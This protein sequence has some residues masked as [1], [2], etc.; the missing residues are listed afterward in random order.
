[1]TTINEHI[2][3]VESELSTL[4]YGSG[5]NV[6]NIWFGDI[7]KADVQV[8]AINFMLAR[9]TRPEDL[10]VIQTSSRITWHL[11][12]DVSCIYSGIEGEQTYKNARKFVDRIYDVIQGQ[13]SS[14]KRLN[15]KC[16]DIECMD[17]DYGLVALG[18]SEPEYMNG[19]LIKMII[20]IVEI[21]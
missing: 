9:R 3:N 21:R 18:I 13:H 5:S 14:N 1:M 6:R 10:Q 4:I 20:E 16:Q 2:E 19:G 17:V 12:Y 7:D 15:G 11:E 8:P